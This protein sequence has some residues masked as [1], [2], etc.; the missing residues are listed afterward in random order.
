MKSGQL[1]HFITVTRE[2][3]VQA[4]DGSGDRESAW[5]KAFDTWANI[6]GLSGRDFIAAKAPQTEISHRIGIRFSDIENNF[7]WQGCR[8]ECDGIIYQIAAVLPDNRGGRQWV[9]LMC[10]SGSAIWVNPTV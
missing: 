5:V 6:E 4:Q 7:D 10:K 1:S 8:I 3:S 2:Q 9:T